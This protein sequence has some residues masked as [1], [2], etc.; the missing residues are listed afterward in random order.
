MTSADPVGPE[1]PTRPEPAPS[2]S[3]SREA[4]IEAAL[5]EFTSR[6]YEAAT[7]A[8]IAERAGV[9]TGA[10]YAHF[11]GKLDL[12]LQ[13][14]GLRRVDD[15]VHD[16]FSAVAGSGQVAHL[17]SRL[18]EDMARPPAPETLLLLDVIVQARRDQRLATTMRRLVGIKLD[19]LSSAA[20]AGRAAGLLDAELSSR[21]VARLLMLVAFGKMVMA[22]LDE[23]PPT[24]AA[25]VRVVDILLSPAGAEDGAVP[26]TPLERVAA[27]A[28]EARRAS[29]ALE[30]AVVEA[31]DQG[32]SL[33]QVGEAAGVS[34]ERVRR[35]VADA[36]CRPA[37]A[38]T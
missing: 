12:L 3:N 36:R 16:V 32:L 13:A 27:R 23:H 6:G 18:S 9:T 28:G 37:V 15:V 11:R 20:E 17:A 38:G 34:H 25:L 2:R 22:A 1:D 31:V 4:L 21:D 26:R 19:E 35:M 24:D 7:V 10:V 8:G 33:R 5:A 29:F 30:A 14:L